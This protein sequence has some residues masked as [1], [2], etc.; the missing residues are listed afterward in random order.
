MD[1]RSPAP[2]SADIGSA[3][4]AS[5][6]CPSPA[7]RPDV[8][9]RPTQPAPG[10]YASHHACRSV[11][12][13]SV[14]RDRRGLHVGDELDQISGYETRSDATVA[15]DLR[16]KPRRV[17]ART[18]RGVERLLARLDA[19]LHADQITDVV[20]ER[21]V[22]ADEEVDRGDRRCEQPLS[23]RRKPVGEPGTGRFRLEVQREL[24]ALDLGV[25]EREI[26]RRSW[27]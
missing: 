22:H 10:R 8:G 27:R 12:S 24:A 19:G 4:Q 6:M 5:G 23:H 3:A 15:E 7:S 25:R 18:G 1:R 13:R 20:R 9:S 14:R 17:A 2:A 26:A 16:E 11:K 21:A